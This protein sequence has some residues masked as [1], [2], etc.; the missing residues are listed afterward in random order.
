MQGIDYD[1]VDWD[2]S[3]DSDEDREAEER[4]F[5][6]DDDEEAEENMTDTDNHVS[7]A[8]AKGTQ[9]RSQ[10]RRVYI[11][12]AAYNCSNKLVRRHPEIAIAPYTCGPL[13]L[14]RFPHSDY[15]PR[16]VDRWV[17]GKMTAGFILVCV[18]PDIK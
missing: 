8:K 10:A 13:A 4:W 11:L 14:V 5:D 7:P 2:E 15:E 18:V 17:R 16:I 1:K 9:R 12:L 3:L 6:E